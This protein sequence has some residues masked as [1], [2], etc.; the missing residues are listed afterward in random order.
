MNKFI[1]AGP[2]VEAPKVEKKKID[3]V[4][5]SVI[6]VLLFIA[7]IVILVLIFS[8]GGD[9]KQEQ[10]DE[11][12]VWRTKYYDY[13]VESNILK[14]ST[15]TDA[16]L[17]DYDNNGIPEL[18]LK[19]YGDED[20]TVVLYIKDD[21]VNK[22]RK[23]FEGEVKLMYHVEDK[24]A[25]WY[26]SEIDGGVDYYTDLSKLAQGNDE[27]VTKKKE[28]II[29]YADSTIEVN[30]KK[31]SAGSLET[32][33]TS[34]VNSYNKDFYINSSLDTKMEKILKDRA[35]S[36]NID[37]VYK[38]FILDKKYNNYINWTS[39]PNKYL[40][41][42]LNKDGTNELFIAYAD[43][44]NWYRNLV[45]TFDQ[46]TH[47]LYK[48]GEIYTFKGIMYNPTKNDFYIMNTIPTGTNVTSH[49]YKMEGTSIVFVRTVIKESP[50][51]YKIEGTSKSKMFI[52]A[53][54]YANYFAGYDYITGYDDI[55][56]YA[57]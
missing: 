10:V 52:E 21:K 42:D 46:K 2:R 40:F 33:L 36:G 49:F 50:K 16:A 4:K 22:S 51:Q 53:T 3:W 57:G 44:D 11:K 39:E 25:K 23:Y 14:G 13:L 12:E 37:E 8:G 24:K 1:D 38:S 5:I 32:D 6:G 18:T 43:N 15:Q 31:L 30:Y 55:L 7:L 34:L 54:E 35:N 41:F 48:V 45:M 27:D 29:D 19:L 28:I 47:V 56:N 17:I 9:E 26:L 20:E